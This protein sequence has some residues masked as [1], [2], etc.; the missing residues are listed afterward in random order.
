MIVFHW[1]WLCL[2]IPS[3]CVI[4][5][6]RVPLIDL[7]DTYSGQLEIVQVSN[8]TDEGEKLHWPLEVDTVKVHR[9]LQVEIALVHDDL[10]R[11]SVSMSI[12]FPLLDSVGFGGLLRLRCGCDR[13]WRRWRVLEDDRFI[14]RFIPRW[15]FGAPIVVVNKL[16]IHSRRW[17]ERRTRISTVRV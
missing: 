8:E 10:S 6:A 14:L 13:Y 15:V 16:G 2:S 4:N 5:K 9:L 17:S 12:A 1:W 11:W 7:L 3:Q